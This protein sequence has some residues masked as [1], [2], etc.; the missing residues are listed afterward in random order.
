MRTTIRRTDA[1]ARPNWKA[2]SACN[3]LPSGNMRISS[4]PPGATTRE[5]AS[6]E[7]YRP[8]LSGRMMR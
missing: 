4:L 5:S 3:A 8:E 6:G 7:M 1:V 2:Y